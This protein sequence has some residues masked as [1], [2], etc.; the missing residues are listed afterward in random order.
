MFPCALLLAACSSGPATDAGPPVGPDGAA[1]A[2]FAEGL[3]SPQARQCFEAACAQEDDA[4]ACFERACPARPEAFELV[5][6]KV[7]YDAQE[8]LF[9][10]EAHVLHSTATWGQVAVPR[11]EPV[12][13]GVTLITPEGEEL[14]LA[15]ATRFPDAI[16]EPFFIS[17]EVGKPVQDLIVG[18]WDRKIE[19]CDS[20]RPGC[21]E[22][23][24]LLDGPMAS[25]PPLFYTNLER[26]RIPTTGLV[27]GLRSAGA[28]AAELSAAGEAALEILNGTLAPFGVSAELAPLAVAESS[29]P[30]QVR[31]AT[32]HDQ[33]L[34]AMLA[35]ALRSAEAP[36]ARG[37]LLQDAAPD[38]LVIELGGDP[39][40]HACL[41][42]HCAQAG[43]LAA[44]EA[45]SCQ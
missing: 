21:K 42:E 6:E 32:L 5:L 40:H 33:P 13:V 9:F 27:L 2:A 7:R 43:D 23:G 3:E 20:E 19:P 14:D 37:E 45:A 28:T 31:A 44:C 18:V 12:H 25:F 16:E 22:F 24:F 30:S 17:S 10:L 4:A 8:Q 36:M 11:E 38:L 1:P 35:G 39:A 41:A 29:G 34:A 15:I 26:Q